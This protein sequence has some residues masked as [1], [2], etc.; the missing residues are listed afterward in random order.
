MPE[1]PVLKAKVVAKALIKMGFF[2][3]HQK[4]SHAR[5]IHKQEPWRRVTIPIHSKD[6]P[7]GTLKSILQQA[8]T[9]VG[10]LSKYL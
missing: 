9:T 3:D 8:S 5:L 1:L 7:K 6:L 4:G 2:I 10:E